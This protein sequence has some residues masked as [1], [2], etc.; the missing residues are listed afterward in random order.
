MAQYTEQQRID[1]LAALDLNRG[2]VSR[3]AREL[4][5]PRPTL[6]LWRDTPVSDIPDTRKTDI[7]GRLARVM[8]SVLDRIGELV[9][10]TENVRDLGVVYGIL[11]DKMLDHRDGRK[12]SEVNVN[13]DNRQVT[14]PRD[15]TVEELRRLAAHDDGDADVLPG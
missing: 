12:G 7:V 11:S 3:T 6:I 15:L 2:N 1:A 14:L 8:D 4:G 13:V 10:R 5:I 9:P